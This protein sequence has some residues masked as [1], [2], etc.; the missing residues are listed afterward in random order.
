ML[1]AA[2]TCGCSSSSTSPLTDVIDDASIRLT[3]GYLSVI[4][5]D[6]GT[7]YQVHLGR[8]CSGSPFVPEVFF[9]LPGPGT[10]PS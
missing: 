7:D 5:L 2:T 9:D 3:D 1:A 10:F 6:G 8:G 4:P